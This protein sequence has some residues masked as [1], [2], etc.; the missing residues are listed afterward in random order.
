MEDSLFKDILIAG[1]GLEADANL[2]EHVLVIA[3][4]EQS[5]LLGLRVIKDESQANSPEILRLKEQFAERCRQ[6]GVTAEPAVVQGK[7]SRAVVERA[8]WADL[9]ALSLVRRGP[10]HTA[11]GFG[12][13]LYRILLHSPR[14]ILILP[15][16]SQ[17]QF[18]HG[19]LAFDGSQKAREALY[20]SAY[21]AVKWQIG[22]SVLTVG[23]GAQGDQIL[24]EAR[25]YLDDQGVQAEFHRQQGAV[26]QEILITR[27]TESGDFFILGGF[28]MQP[29][30][31]RFKGS[32]VDQLLH[33]ISHPI[34][35]CR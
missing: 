30:L 24:D 29:I 26:V 15:Q 17:S 4:R 14:P 28:G 32:T 20:L 12:S 13:E 35:I 10:A 1:R 8:A 3:Q 33:Q 18:K 23:V 2:L 31:V 34:F 22:L 25:Q 11:L 21:M 6:A 7:V 19:V 16:G 27:E 9:L 5:R